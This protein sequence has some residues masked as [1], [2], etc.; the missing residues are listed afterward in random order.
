MQIVE[1][2]TYIHS[3]NIGHL[4]IN[5]EVFMIDS[6]NNIKLCDFKFGVIYKEKEKI[7]TSYKQLENMFSCPEIH[8]RKPFL[9]VLADVWSSGVVLYHVLTG[10]TPF[11]NIN[12]LQLTKSIIKAEYFI[13]ENTSQEFIELFNNLLDYRE[14]KRFRL[15][16]IYNSAIFKAKNIIKPNPPLGYSV[17]VVKEVLNFCKNNYNIKPV[18]AEKNLTEGDINKTTSI[19][20]QVINNIRKDKKDFGMKDY[21]D[22]SNLI[23]QNAESYMK[24]QE[25]NK[26]KNEQEEAKILTNQKNILKALENV[27]VKYLLF[28][29]N[30][31]IAI[32]NAEKNKIAQNSQRQSRFPTYFSKQTENLKRKRNSVFMLEPRAF[33][34]L[35]KANSNVRNPKRRS[36]LKKLMISLKFWRKMKCS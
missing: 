11:N 35:K 33:V 36:T 15:D 18:V 24:Q 20:K 6:K 4:N 23:K 32:Q 26:T 1:M 9:P 14:D 17:P 12:N 7:T 22:E 5:P 2:L 29:K 25:E 31:E 21:T 13:P 27:K 10:E 8:I 3:L 34:G 28:K 16:D 30:K 19:Y